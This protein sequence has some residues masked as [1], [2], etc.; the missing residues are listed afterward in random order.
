MPR[1]DPTETPQHCAEKVE[2]FDQRELIEV[3]H[4]AF[5]ASLFFSGESAA[6]GALLNL[7]LVT[8]IIEALFR[9]L[10]LKEL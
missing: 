2:P 10:P 5:A 9:L 8:F 4:R 6:V 1:V 3:S 7:T